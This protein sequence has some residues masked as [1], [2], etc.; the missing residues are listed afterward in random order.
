MHLARAPLTS[1]GTFPCPLLGAVFALV[2][3]TKRQL[4]EICLGERA[5]SGGVFCLPG[6]HAQFFLN[7]VEGSKL[8]CL[9]NKCGPPIWHEFW[10]IPRDPLNPGGCAACSHPNQV[11]PSCPSRVDPVWT[12]TARPRAGLVD[13]T[14]YHSIRKPHMLKAV[15]FQPPKGTPNPI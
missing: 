13:H 15:S 11:S 3:R 7:D 10:V 9:W 12:W 8:T 5:N 1:R 6:T 4:F 14:S 2:R